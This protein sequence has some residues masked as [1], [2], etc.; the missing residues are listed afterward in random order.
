MHEQTSTTRDAWRSRLIERMD[1]SGM[2]DRSISAA[3]GLSPNYVNHIRRLGKAPGVDVLISICAAIGVSLTYVMTGAD[4]DPETEEVLSLF[5]RLPDSDR[6]LFL[7]FL[8][9]LPGAQ[10]RP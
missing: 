1:A 5:S 10:A 8:R 3:A 2:S 4:I 9:R 6:Q 7:D